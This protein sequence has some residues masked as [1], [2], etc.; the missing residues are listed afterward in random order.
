MEQESPSPS[1][2]QWEE[3]GQ[4]EKAGTCE[5]GYLG[6]SVSSGPLPTIWKKLQPSIKFKLKV[7]PELSDL[8]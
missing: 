5:R 6:I 4:K 3:R 2:G 7:T 1:Q 8:C